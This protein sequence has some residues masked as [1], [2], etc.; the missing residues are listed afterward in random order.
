MPRT[1]K[2]KISGADR[3]F[4]FE[5]DDGL[6]ASPRGL[7]VRQYLEWL[8]QN[9]P[10]DE[11]PNTANI[12]S[13]LPEQPVHVR[14]MA[15]E[16]MGRNRLATFRVGSYMRPCPRFEV[17]IAYYEDLPDEYSVEAWL[18][19]VPHELV[20]VAQFNERYGGRVPAD[21]SLEEQ[22]DWYNLDVED[23]A[24]HL[25]RTSTPEFAETHPDLL[26]APGLLDGLASFPNTA[27]PPGR[28]KKQTPKKRPTRTPPV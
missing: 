8:C 25:E 26:N 9:V 15:K 20:H 23:E 14:L 13:R 17:R 3:T 18:A 10:D 21:I 19:S 5:A 16:D 4:V 27:T 24:V 7:L 6:Q 12:L 11:R 1:S 28:A 22:R 2:S